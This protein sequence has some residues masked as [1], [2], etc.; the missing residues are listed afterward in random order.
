MIPPRYQ[1]AS[2]ETDV[3]ER[4]KLLLRNMGESKKGIYIHGAIGTGKTHI[5]Y[6]ILKK[7]NEISR[8]GGELWNT[9]E[10][11]R[12]IKDDFDRPYIDKRRVCEKLMESSKILFLDD[13]GVEKAT[14]FVQETFYMLINKQYNEKFP[15]IFTSNKSVSEL[16]EHVGERTASRIV[17]MCDV[18]ELTGEDRRI[19]GR[20]KVV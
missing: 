17:E 12:E 20:T 5:A 10:L 7:M 11:L 19:A 9:T 18:V 1:E 3:P 8:Y 14:E 6:A 15:I 2:Y 4:I 16:A 13:I